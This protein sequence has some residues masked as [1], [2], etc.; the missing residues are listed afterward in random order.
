[1]SDAIIIDPTLAIIAGL[2]ETVTNRCV[3][4]METLVADCSQDRDIPFKEGNME[5]SVRVMP[6]IDGCGATADWVTPYARKQWF[7]VQ[8]H[9]N[10]GSDHW[11]EK[12]RN[13]HDTKY[14]NIVDG[15]TP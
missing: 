9:P 10:G 5:R 8:N 12:T 13:R 15:G 2:K 11:A 7:V 3:L 14:R 4:A 1:M 6:T